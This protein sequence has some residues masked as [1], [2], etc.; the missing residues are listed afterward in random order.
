MLPKHYD[1][2]ESQEMLALMLL[3][4]Q[5]RINVYCNPSA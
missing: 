4:S 3:L 5:V 1:I 2:S